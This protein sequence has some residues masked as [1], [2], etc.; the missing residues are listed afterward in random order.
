MWWLVWWCGISGEGA[1]LCSYH[2]LLCYR[3]AVKSTPPHLTL[4]STYAVMSAL[5]SC[6]VATLGGGAAAEAYPAACWG[7]WRVAAGA[8]AAVRCDK[9]SP[10]TKSSGCASEAAT[11]A[12]DVDDSAALPTSRASQL[13]GR[14]IV[15][16]CCGADLAVLNAGSSELATTL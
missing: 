15:A 2:P 5:T 10:P 16:V 3:V 13:A 4:T 8:A 14:A 7:G 12:A 1:Q 9:S 6:W 11:A